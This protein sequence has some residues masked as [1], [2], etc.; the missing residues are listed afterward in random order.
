MGRQI[1][2]RLR[3]IVDSVVE[4]KDL[5]KAKEILVAFVKSTRI[6]EIDK[7]RIEFKT[8]QIYRKDEFEVYVYN[9]ILKYELGGVLRK[10]LNGGEFTYGKR[11]K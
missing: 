9:S 3:R 10:S 2:S 1:Q 7:R 11:E 5:K 8:A 6:K 4:E